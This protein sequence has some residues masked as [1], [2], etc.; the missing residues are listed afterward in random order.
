MSLAA[1]D[2]QF[3]NEK[4]IFVNFVYGFHGGQSHAAV[5]ESRRRFVNR[6]RP[7]RSVGVQQEPL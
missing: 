2:L 4:Y 6:R 3:T 1:T 7:N 5:Q